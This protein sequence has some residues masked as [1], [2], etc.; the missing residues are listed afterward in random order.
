VISEIEFTRA[1]AQLDQAKAQLDQAK[2]QLSFTRVKAPFNG[3]IETHFIE[4]GELAAPGSPLIRIV[5]NLSVNLV[6]GVPERYALDVTQGTPVT[7]RF[8]AYNG[9]EQKA[10]VS[11]VSNVID[12]V[13][14]TFQIKIRL[15]NPAGTLKPEM[16]A[17]L[18]LQIGV[19]DKAIV[20]PQAAILFDEEGPY[21]YVVESEGDTLIARR[22]R[23]K[24]GPTS[25][26]LTLIREGLHPGDRVIVVG[27]SNLGE[28]DLVS[29]IRLHPQ[30]TS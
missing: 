11:F 18:T 30:V 29:I 3:R 21:V 9:E 14:R 13:S 19:Y 1:K 20:L 24:T 16:V 25:G 12:P 4:E 6:A 7:V 22:K 10:Q 17:N 26:N 5:N 23:I 2:T 15:D 8:S 28:G 27:Q